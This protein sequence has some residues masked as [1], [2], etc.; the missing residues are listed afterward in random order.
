MST[1]VSKGSRNRTRP[2]R[3]TFG[4]GLSGVFREFRNHHPDQSGERL[5]GYSDLATLISVRSIMCPRNPGF[6]WR[7][8]QDWRHGGRHQKDVCKFSTF[9]LCARKTCGT[10][11]NCRGH[12]ERSGIADTRAI[13]KTLTQHMENGMLIEILRNGNKV[14]EQT[15]FVSNKT[16]NRIR[17]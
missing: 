2:K 7:G 4:S 17:R 5:V 6:G 11:T 15:T 9:F 13:T 14:Y 10:K 3:G 12:V 1:S 16:Q 8:A